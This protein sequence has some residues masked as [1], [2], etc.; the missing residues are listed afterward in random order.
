MD[1]LLV[2]GASGFL[3]W[4]ICVFA[5]EKWD[6]I[7]MHLSHDI[8]CEGIFR[9]K[10]DITDFTDVE[11]VFERTRPDAVIHVAAMPDP[12]FCELNAA[13]SWRINVEASEHI[14]SLC[15]KYGS[16]CAFT[17]TDLVFTEIIRHTP[18]RISSALSVFTGNIRQ[19][20]K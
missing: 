20:R 15:K 16:R 11:E 13:Q 19:K 18:N 6:V 4:N 10:C 7:G 9:E 5:K 2:T 8:P 17:S 14:A 1:K 12:N 3:G